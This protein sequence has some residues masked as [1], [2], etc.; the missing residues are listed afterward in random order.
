MQHPNEGETAVNES[1]EAH[2]LIIRNMRV[3]EE[4]P[5]VV[6]EVTKAVF[7]RINEKIEQ[8]GQTD[9]GTYLAYLQFTTYG[10]RSSYWLS[11]LIG[12]TK[13][14]SGFYFS[15][16]PV[17]ITG[18]TG[19]KGAR[20]G[21]AWAKYLA[22]HLPDFPVVRQC[23]FRLEGEDLFLPVRLDVE[24]L[25]EAYPDSLDDALLPIDEA[26]RKITEILPELD[27]LIASAKAHFGSEESEA[28]TSPA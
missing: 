8:W 28:D 12:A 22:D 9:N 26:L 27:R 13:D 1:H 25:A 11:R 20:P 2:R 10:E 15:V 7:K 3:L 5:E 24:E 23:G 19:R 14:E 21:K 6:E 4:A 17:W 18:N 16:L